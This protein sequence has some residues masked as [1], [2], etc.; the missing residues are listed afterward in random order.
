MK[1]TLSFCLVIAAAAFVTYAGSLVRGR[2]SVSAATLTFTKDVAPIIQ[3]NC[4]VCHRP[5][6][7]APM[8]FMDYKDVRPWAR[9]IRE[10]VRTREMPPWFADPQHGAFSNDCRLTQ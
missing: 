10:K 7:V 6:E 1:R 2:Q 5:G 3:K 4:Q 9:S 8:A